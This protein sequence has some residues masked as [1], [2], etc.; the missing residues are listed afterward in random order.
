M[1]DACNSLDAKNHYLFLMQLL[2]LSIDSSG[3]KQPN[4]ASHISFEQFE[5]SN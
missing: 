4:L 3:I 2:P 5:H 1:N